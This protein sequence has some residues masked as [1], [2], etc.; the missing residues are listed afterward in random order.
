MKRALAAHRII[1]THEVCPH[2]FLVRN[3]DVIDIAEGQLPAVDG[4]KSIR[5]DAVW[6]KLLKA[7]GKLFRPLVE[8]DHV[9]EIDVP[10]VMTSALIRG[11]L[12]MIFKSRRKGD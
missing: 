9:D 4:R 3:T 10:D 6:S 12:E 2:P 1:R 7:G 5:L 11:S 8:V